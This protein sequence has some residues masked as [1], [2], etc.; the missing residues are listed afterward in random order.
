MAAVD[1]DDLNRWARVAA[2]E[3]AVDVAAELAAPL[4]DLRDRLAMLADRIDRH[5]AYQTGPEPYPWKQLQAL[6]QDLAGAYL[7]TTSMSRLASDL[8]ATIAALG[9]V[10]VE[11]DDVERLVEAAVQLARH[12][13]G[14]GTELL[15]DVGPVPS[16]R[17]PAGELTLAVAKMIAVC[18]ASAHPVE[19]SALSVRCRLEPEGVVIAASDNGRGVPDAAA[20]LIGVLAP[21]AQRLGG[22]FDGHSQPEQGSIFELRLPPLPSG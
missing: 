12:R 22:S 19:R 15:V 3:V 17:A 6:R 20:E 5:V 14:P 8:G 7:E 2:G 11:I 18:A 1:D 4:A 16:V 21:F 13:L 10:A 9:A